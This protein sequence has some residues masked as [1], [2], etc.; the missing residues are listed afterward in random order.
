MASQMQLSNVFFLPFQPSELATSI[1]SAAGVNLIPLVPGG[2]KTALPSK[3]GVCLSC[4]Q[5]IV[6]AF[7]DDCRFAQLVR[8]YDAGDC[9]SANDGR[10]LADVIKALA[11][12]QKE[13]GR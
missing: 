10:Q 9:V 12:V 5:P 6:F 11:S 4:G 1:Y 7:G 2:V 8:E 13:C 3:T